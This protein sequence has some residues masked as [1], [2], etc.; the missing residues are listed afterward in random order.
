[1]KYRLLKYDAV[2]VYKPTRCIKI[3]VIRLYFPIDA[4]HVS[5]YVSPSSGAIFYKL[6]IAFGVRRYVWLLCG[7]RKGCSFLKPHKQ[8]DVLA[9]TNAMYSL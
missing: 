1:M 6:Y 9:Y 7:C 2:Y 3:L 8:P 5:I 4:L